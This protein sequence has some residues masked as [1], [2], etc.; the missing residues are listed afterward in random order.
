VSPVKYELGFHIP[1]DGI[2]HTHRRVN[3]KSYND[4]EVF[5]AIEGGITRDFGHRFNNETLC[6]TFH[7]L[8]GM[9]IHLTIH[10]CSPE[11]HVELQN[12]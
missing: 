2:I 6:I 8:L 3:L 11:C 12:S 9:L 4:W 10:Q 7:L 5:A 1:E